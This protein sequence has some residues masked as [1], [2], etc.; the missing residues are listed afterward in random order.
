MTREEVLAFINE[1]LLDDDKE[2]V[3]EDN[4]LKDVIEESLDY[5][6]FFLELKERYPWLNEKT[7]VSEI[8]RLGDVSISGLITT[9]IDTEK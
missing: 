4:Q 6:V 8:I 7:L 2:A 9:L 3:T 1:I 5:A